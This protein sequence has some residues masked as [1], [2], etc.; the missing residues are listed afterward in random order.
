MRVRVVHGEAKKAWPCAL[1]GEEMWRR[2]SRREGK[3][4]AGLTSGGEDERMVV[5]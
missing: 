4:N 2:R 1:F 3:G 5:Q